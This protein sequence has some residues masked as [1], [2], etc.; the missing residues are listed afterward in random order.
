MKRKRKTW[1]CYCI[2]MQIVKD[3]EHVDREEKVS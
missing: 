1:D 3:S 2:N